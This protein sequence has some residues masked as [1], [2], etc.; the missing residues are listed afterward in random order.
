M[1]TGLGSS[2]ARRVLARGAILFAIAAAFVF[3]SS[4]PAA[5]GTAPPAF[6]APVAYD[7]DWYPQDMKIADL[8]GDGVQDIVTADAG[9]GDVS[10]LLGKGDGTFSALPDTDVGPGAS[11]VAVADLNGDGTP[12]LVVADLYA[13]NIAIL[14]GNGDGTFGAPSFISILGLHHGSSG[15]NHLA[16]GDMNGDGSSDVAVS[17]S[18]GSISVLLGNGDGTFAAPTVYP[19]GSDDEWV[20]LADLNGDGILDIASVTSDAVSVLLG[21]GDGTFKPAVAYAAG[22]S[23]A[24]VA[25][26][27]LN[28]DARPDLVVANWG[29]GTVSVLAGEGGG[30]FAAPVAYSIGTASRPKSVAV[31]DLNGDGTPDLA[32]A[33]FDSSD[34][35]VLLGNGDGTFSAPIGVD[36]GGNRGFSIAAADLNGDGAPDL[37]VTKGSL[38]SLSVLLSASDRTPPT[39]TVSAAAGAAPYTAATWTNQAV[40]VTFACTDSG[41]GV[42][43]LTPSGPQTVTD[44]GVTTPRRQLCGQGRQRLDVLVRGLDRQ[45]PADDHLERSSRHLRADGHRHDHV[46]RDRRALRHCL[47]DV[48]G[49]L[50]TGMDPARIEH[51]HRDRDGRRREHRLWIDE[52]RRSRD[53]QRSLRADPELRDAPRRRRSALRS[54]HRSGARRRA[55]QDED[56]RHARPCVHGGVEARQPAARIL[57]GRRADAHAARAAALAR[58]STSAGITAWSLVRRPPGPP[59]SASR[60][61]ARQPSSTLSP[62][63]QELGRTTCPGA[64]ALLADLRRFSVGR[65]SRAHRGGGRAQRVLGVRDVHPSG[66]PR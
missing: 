54:A 49:R 65:G 29:Q 37:V 46:Q 22:P 6:A 64:V 40:T 10:V 14:L 48:P 17:D 47:V 38:A 59:R 34:V 61:S 23:P 41:S 35:A 9:Y 8:N 20:A 42:E 44:D 55:R 32:V 63:N 19:S 13:A 27:D 51:A 1:G 18:D 60:F 33:V 53:V 43:S 26:A 30:T 16:I 52:L 21:N 12:D 62:R 58:P 4:G 56:R 45:R 28:G 7:T 24:S 57:G 66:P 50:G 25:V 15:V 39:L 5:A 31:A 2:R 3:C 36:A 11:A